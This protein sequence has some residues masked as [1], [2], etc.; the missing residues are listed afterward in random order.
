LDLACCGNA[1]KKEKED[2]DDKKKKSK[3]QKIEFR[4]GIIVKK[5]RKNKTENSVHLLTKI[6]KIVHKKKHWKFLSYH[7]KRS[8]SVSQQTFLLTALK[9]LLR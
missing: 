4:V 7:E 5:E 3:N 9:K 6:E 8:F 2:N 1:C